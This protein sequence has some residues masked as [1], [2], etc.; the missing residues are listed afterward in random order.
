MLGGKRENKKEKLARILANLAVIGCLVASPDLVIM[1]IVLPSPT[2]GEESS[3]SCC[4]LQ[5]L[6]V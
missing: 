4:Q 6:Q 1:P 2:E 5:V 3:L